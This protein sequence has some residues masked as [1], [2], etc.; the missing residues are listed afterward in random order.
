MG[1]VKKNIKA[2][3]EPE[4]IQIHTFK[5]KQNCDVPR[6]KHRLIQAFAVSAKFYFC[7]IYIQLKP[8]FV[9]TKHQQRSLF[10]VSRSFAGNLKVSQDGFYF[11]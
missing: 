7:F 4:M 2:F 8:L 5:R 10:L 1:Q 3:S 9:G 11:N 6:I